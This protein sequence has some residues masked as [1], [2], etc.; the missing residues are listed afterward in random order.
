VRGAAL[1]DGDRVV[2]H[3][4]NDYRYESGG[5]NRIGDPNY[6]ALGD[7]SLWESWLEAPDYLGGTGGG[8]PYNLDPD[9]EGKGQN[10][11]PPGNAGSPAPSG[12]AGGAAAL[13]GLAIIRDGK[14]PLASLAGWK[15][16]FAD[17]KQGA[18]YYEAVSFAQ[19]NGLMG[20]TAPDTFAPDASLS[21]AM[22]VT[23][24]WRLDNTPEAKGAAFSDVKAG[25]WFVGAVAWASTNGVAA[26]YG[27]G[28]FG[29]DDDITRE[30]L[31]AIL[32]NYAVYRGLPIAGADYAAA[33]YK[34]AYADAG[35]VSAWAQASMK[36]A[37]NLNL[38][39]G[40][41]ATALDPLGK[42]TRAEAAAI[43]QRFITLALA[44]PHAPAEDL[45]V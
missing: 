39:G 43:L 33:S 2:W 3:Y 35:M 11:A 34:A 7:G 29:P 32:H 6:P 42:A 31:A 23:V 22:L 5:W 41:T 25:D 17:V 8:N 45:S 40:R 9:E 24:L 30:Q 44:P 12:G 1:K 38:I 20:G 10:T 28:L 14:A 19:A 13:P 36:W 15:N 21:R 18:W 4:I 37:N 26:G 27:G 16:P